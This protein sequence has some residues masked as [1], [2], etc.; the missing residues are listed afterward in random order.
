MH[1]K[2]THTRSRSRVEKS[3]Q[4][5]AATIFGVNGAT[6]KS[7]RFEDRTE[8][9][10]N[11]HFHSHKKGQQKIVWLGQYDTMAIVTFWFASNGHLFLAC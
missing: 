10:S 3:S 4:Y 1:K 7:F 11:Y 6:G 9:F 5:M 2:H 8:L